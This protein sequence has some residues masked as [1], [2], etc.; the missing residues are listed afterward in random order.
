MHL[1]DLTGKRFGRLVVIERAPRK[2]KTK[3]TMWRCKCDCGNITD[4][5]A[6]HLKDGLVRSCGC[7]LRDSARANHISHNHSKERLYKIWADM[8]QRCTNP[9]R[10]R[11]PLYGGRGVKVCKE[12]S[13]DYMS[14]R[15]W[16]YA[17]GYDENAPRGVCTIDRIDPDGNYE[18][19]NCRWANMQTQALNRHAKGYLS[20]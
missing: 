9:K 16:A 18:P 6:S 20:S 17:N 12:W 1:V 2:G 11:Y 5:R 4:V 10:P 13:D 7:F 14:F 8:K 15:N 3:A 19:S